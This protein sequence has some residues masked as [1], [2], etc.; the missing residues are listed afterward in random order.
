MGNTFKENSE[1]LGRKV[2][3]TKIQY[4][5]LLLNHRIMHR[6]GGNKDGKTNGMD[7]SDSG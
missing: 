3:K 1:K 4:D 5:R 6:S 7:K 2:L